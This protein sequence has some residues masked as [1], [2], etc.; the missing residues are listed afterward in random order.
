MN[1]LI[2]KDSLNYTQNIDIP[3]ITGSVYLFYI[4]LF[5][6]DISLLN[7]TFLNNTFFINDFER[8]MDKFWCSQNDETEKLD[9]T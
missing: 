9:V 6:L 2:L 5:F 4:Y 1:I 3:C 8:E 7:N